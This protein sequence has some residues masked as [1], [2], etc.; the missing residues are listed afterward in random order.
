[1]ISWLLILLRSGGRAKRGARGSLNLKS[2]ICGAE[3][4]AR[5]WRSPVRRQ[6]RG[7]DDRVP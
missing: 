6:K 2:S 4:P 7:D 1:M 5:G 3:F